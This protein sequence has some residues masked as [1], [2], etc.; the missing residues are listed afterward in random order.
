M[1]AD[2]FITY[3]HND[4]L[5][6][7]WI[8][9]VLKEV[10]FSI[11]MDSWDFL[12]GQ[13]PIEKVEHMTTISNSVLVLISER[14]IQEVGDAVSWKAVIEKFSSGGTK[15]VMLL[16][17]DSCE[18]EKVLGAVIYTNLFG[19]K[20]AEA[21]KRLLTA[22][23][24][25]TADEKEPVLM[26]VTTMTREEVLGKRKAELD[27]L[28][29]TT[30]K[31]QYHMKLDLEQEVEKEVDV[32]D[33]KT[34]K[35]REKRI[36]WVWET[37]KLETVL[38]DENNYI[39]VNPSGMGKTTFL[40]YAACVLLDRA[41]D[42]PFVP[43]LTTCIALN[44]REGSIANFIHQRVESFFNN[45]Q[46]AVVHGEWDNL[47]VLLDA[48][49]QARDVDDIAASL[50]IHDRYH[51]YKKA[52]I[53]LSSRQN[54]ADKVKT[55]FKK[56]SLKLPE[57]DEVR[58][59]LGE[60][61]YKKLEG[62][63]TATRELVTVPVLLEMLKTIT[64]KRYKASKLWNRADLYTE[65]TRI[66]IDQ[67][68][69]KPRFWQDS[70]SIRHFIDNE[71]E[72]A[73]EKIA[74]F[75]LAE[76]K[77]LEIEKDKLVQYCETPEKKEALLNIGIILEL[78][79]DREQK[80]VFRH[81]SFQAYFAARYMYYQQPQ[82]FRK[83]VGDITF[84]YHDVWY[85]VMRFF[86]GLEK[87]PQKVEVIIDS[88]YQTD[89]KKVDLICELKF[90]FTV[91]L[92]SDASAD[93][94]FIQRIY[95]QLRELLNNNKK[96]LNYFLSNNDKF[97]KSNDEQRKFILSIIESQIR[98]EDWDITSSAAEALKKICKAKD[99]PLLKNLLGDMDCD[100]RGAATVALGKNST[101]KDIP[102]LEPL[103]RDEVSYVRSSAT[104]TLGK[105][106]TLEHIPILENLLR[107][108]DE[109]V[110][111]AAARAL[112]K[113]GTSNDIHLLVPLLSDKNDFVRRTA[114][115]VLRDIVKAGDI[116]LQEPLLRDKDMRRA[117]A[118]ALGKIGT[119]KNIPLLGPLLRD[120]DEDVRC[121]AAEALGKIGISKNIPLLAPLLRDKNIRVQWA[122]RDA[123]AKIFKSQ[124]ISFLAPLLRNKAEDVRCAAADALGFIG[125]TEHIPLLQP[126]LSD[127][128]HLLRPFPSDILVSRT[129]A[130]AIDKICQRST[131]KLSIDRILPEKK[132]ISVKPFSSQN[133]NILH[134]SD[135]HYALEKDPTIT[136]IFHEFLRDIQ[137][138]RAQQNNKKI[139]SICLTGDIAQSG[140]K[141]QY[142]SINEK[143]NDILNTTGCSKD[144]LFIIPG[145]HDVHEYEYISDKGKTTIE[146]VRDNKINID[147]GVLSNFENYCEFQEK[148]KYYY[149]FV[150]S[151]GYVNS[152]TL[153]DK[154]SGSPKPWYSR[155]LQDF[156]VRI[157]GLNSA[158]FCL[159][160]FS[161]YGKIRMG[162]HQFH[163]AYFQGKPGNVQKGELVILLTHHPVNWLAEN[164][165]EDY[166][167]LMERYG[168]IHL[169]GHIHKTKIVKKQKLF[170]SSGG[171]VSIGTGSL[172]GEKGEEDINTYHIIT[173]DFENQEL[174]VWARRWNPDLG[175]WTVYHDDGNNR[176]PLPHSTVLINRE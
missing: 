144:H 86:V 1:K 78:F 159:K 147:T 30:I 35:V 61:N 148:F 153:T 19:M 43:L 69:S 123:L 85:E 151:S 97:N 140:Q 103:L 11:L 107:D 28:L 164:E 145:N 10:P 6:A 112:G 113:I 82:L 163:E 172:Y 32:K 80:I 135:I 96:Y 41:G 50:Q 134:I 12:P 39:L 66:L 120:K 79:E 90:I 142:E 94:K 84:F 76:N 89:S 83:L 20:E 160:E 109:D 70:L 81:Q 54:T 138:W 63:I 14:F 67:E 8:A 133:L 16:R 98:D 95:K 121:V 158:L 175:E 139:H 161:E 176:F 57:E 26:Q 77:I 21:R 108:K 136:C 34:G 59:Y 114:E 102:L 56:I 71:L 38:T 129:A 93:L 154:R 115:D 48:L 17:I 170:S 91:F 173:L 127:R 155:K 33:E 62:H 165:F 42:Y 116:P 152:L 46:T 141:N 100:F 58:H 150:K 64:E 166:T 130:K 128:I 162:T 23:G 105:I 24:S 118:E 49:D 169:H 74:F 99:I 18:V 157:I 55:V 110:R 53:L 75:S 171:Y 25:A 5:A 15:A 3:H 9:G 119:S 174:H 167:T 4:E 72:Q 104:E 68:R 106:G 22:V 27:E 101:S 51:Y 2:F 143:I 7:R 156:P 29:N 36:Q 47:C 52:K 168:I 137:K 87:D 60:E 44:N 73:L 92:M 111:R 131:P 40:N 124:D 122:A 132:T 65:F 117:T 126:L 45:S 88:I 37:V 149:E 31:H 146:E 13:N 125:T